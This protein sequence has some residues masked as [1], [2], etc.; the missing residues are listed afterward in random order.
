MSSLALLEVQR[1]LYSKLQGDGV[2]MSMVTGVY[3]VVPQRSVVPYVVIGDGECRDVEADSLNLSELRLQLD[4]WSDIGG[5]KN[6][7]TIMNRMHAILHMGTLTLTGFTQVLMRCEQADTELTEQGSHIHG[8][9][10]VRIA[11]V[12]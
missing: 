11:V 5:R 1:A 3:D 8:T 12:E 4:I 10:I 2:L 6:A 7:L 9:M